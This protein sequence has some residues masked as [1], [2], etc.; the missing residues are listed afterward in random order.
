MLYTA[1]TLSHNKVMSHSHAIYA[2]YSIPE[3]VAQISQI[4]LLAFF[5]FFAF[6]RQGASMGE[7][8]KNAKKI[9]ESAYYRVWSIDLHH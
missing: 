6:L 8:L 1:H 5:V 2:V 9:Q 7:G 4:A 3:P